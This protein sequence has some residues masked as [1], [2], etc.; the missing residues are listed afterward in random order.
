MQSFNLSRE[1][2][3]PRDFDLIHVGIELFVSSLRLALD[4]DLPA[5]ELSGD[6]VAQEAGTLTICQTNTVLKD[7]GQVESNRRKHLGMVS[8]VERG[9]R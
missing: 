4:I 8:E 2:L 9:W 6:L 1:G 5:R 7:P 3:V